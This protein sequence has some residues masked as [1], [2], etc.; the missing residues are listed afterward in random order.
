MREPEVCLPNRALRGG[1]RRATSAVL[2]LPGGQEDST[3]ATSRRQLSY[4]RLLDIYYGLRQG[5][6]DCAV[7]LLH[8]RVRGWNAS[9]VGDPAPVTDAL[10]AL[11]TI[12][13]KHPGAPVALLGHSMGRRTAFEVSDHPAVVGACALAPW[14]PEGEPLPMARADQRFV[15]AH[16]S[17]DTM[18]AATLSRRFAARLRATGVPVAWLEQPGGGH[19]LLSQPVLWHRFAVRTTLGVVGDSWLPAGVETALAAEGEDAFGTPLA[20]FRV[21]P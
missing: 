19:G 16:G 7:Y 18:T 9:A 14:L 21:I 20:Q 15:I 4:L 13:R 3:Q 6:A 10:W 17:A 1:R 5:S 11:N 8:Y 2:V 12:S